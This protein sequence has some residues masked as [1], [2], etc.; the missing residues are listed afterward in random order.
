[1]PESLEPGTRALRGGFCSRV[2]L[3]DVRL[4]DMHGHALARALRGR[5]ET[6][7]A[8]LIA[9]S[10][11]GQDRDRARSAAAGINHRLVKP[12]DLP[13]WSKLSRENSPQIPN[14]EL[15]I[16]IFCRDPNRYSPF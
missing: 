13:E 7:S 14:A 1:M 6:S 11:Y 10:G 3:V 15:T 9:V 4:P 16:V 12:V 8:M 5:A 2:V